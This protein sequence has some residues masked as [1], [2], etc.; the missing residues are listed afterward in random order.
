MLIATTQSDNQERQLIDAVRSY[1]SELP[2]R[3]G[4]QSRNTG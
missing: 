4:I 3:G 1:S 2:F